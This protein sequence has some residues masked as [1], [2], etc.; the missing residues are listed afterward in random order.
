MCLNFSLLR[1]SARLQN[2]GLGSKP[3]DFVP[4]PDSRDTEQNFLILPTICNNATVILCTKFQQ[5]L[6]HSQRSLYRDLS[7][8]IPRFPD[9]LSRGSLK[10]PELPLRFSL[11]LLQVFQ[12][13]WELKGVVGCAGGAIH[14]VTGRWGFPRLLQ[15]CTQKKCER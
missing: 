8:P 7:Q 4:S 9:P 12:R 3:E 5:P 13:G 2:G 15:T 14:G 6:S 11:L 10:L 1:H